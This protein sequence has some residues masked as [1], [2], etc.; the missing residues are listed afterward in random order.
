M[1]V[2]HRYW[3]LRSIAAEEGEVTTRVKRSDYVPQ[4]GVAN[5]LG[6]IALF[7]SRDC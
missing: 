1:P 3:P 5:A 6:V 2:F 7:I 4:N